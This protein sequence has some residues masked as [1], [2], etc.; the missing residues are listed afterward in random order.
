MMEIGKAVLKCEAEI[1]STNNWRLSAEMLEQLEVL[2]KC[3][4]NDYIF[5]YFEPVVMNRILYAVS[6]PKRKRKFTRILIRCLTDMYLLLSWF[7]EAFAGSHG[8]W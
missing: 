7:T 2:P 6:L 3:F 1:A 8:C 5:T 4:P